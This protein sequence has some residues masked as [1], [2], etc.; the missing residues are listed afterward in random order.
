MEIYQL[1][2]LVKDEKGSIK[3][4]VQPLFSQESQALKVRDRYLEKYGPAFIQSRIDA[5]TVY[6]NANEYHQV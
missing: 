5:R 1:S 2:I 6:E 4:L 3:E